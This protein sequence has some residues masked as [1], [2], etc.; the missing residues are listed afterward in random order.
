MNAWTSGMINAATEKSNAIAAATDSQTRS[1]RPPL[2]RPPAA[3]VLDR[4]SAESSG[5]S[6]SQSKWLLCPQSQRELYRARSKV[7]ALTTVEEISIT[8]VIP[9]PTSP[10]PAA[11][12][13]PERA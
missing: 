13:A 11:K 1:F 4:A 2:I 6:N 12:P 9:P 5:T 10:L 3:T 7:P 8:A